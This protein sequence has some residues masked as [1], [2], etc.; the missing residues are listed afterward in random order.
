MSSSFQGL[1]MMMMMMWMEKRSTVRR[2]KMSGN[3][4]YCHWLTLQPAVWR[5]AA[6]KIS[7]AVTCCADPFWWW[8]SSVDWKR[9]ISECRFKRGGGKEAATAWP[10][11]RF[12]LLYFST[13]MVKWVWK[14]RKKKIKKEWK[15]ARENVCLCACVLN[16]HC[17]RYILSFS[18]GN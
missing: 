4:C 3:C 16:V 17:H 18:T 14:R 1:M 2:W 6:A 5:T 9:Q 12:Y 15:K 11:F 10:L 8:S 7:A 13:L